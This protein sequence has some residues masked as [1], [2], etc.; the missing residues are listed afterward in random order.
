ML[1]FNV[2][3]HASGDPKLLTISGKNGAVALPIVRHAKD[4]FLATKGGSEPQRGAYRD[5]DLVIPASQ[6]SPRAGLVNGAKSRVLRDF[7]WFTRSPL[8]LGVCSVNSN[9]SR[10]K[11]FIY[12]SI[13][14][15]IRA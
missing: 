9:I 2:T 13:L 12:L 15:T 3:G 10:E 8:S 7:T 14:P 6:D 4:E 11:K 1:R 5:L